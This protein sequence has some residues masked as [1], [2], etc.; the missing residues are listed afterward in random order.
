M[1]RPGTSEVVDRALDRRAVSAVPRS[2]RRCASL[3]RDWT[4][5]GTFDAGRTALRLGDLGRRRA[6]DAG[7]SPHRLFVAALQARPTP[8]ASTP[9]RPQIESDPRLTLE[10]K[11]ERASTPTSRRCCRTSSASS[12]LSIS[13]IFSIGAVIGA[14]ITMY[15]SVASRTGGDRHAARAGLLAHGDPGRVSRRGAAAGRDR[16]RRRAR[17][18]RRSCRR[19]RSR[20]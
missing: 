13:V 10:A 18:A 5:V 20:R 4:V 3:P 17:R 2:A 14:M 6:D 8:T 16:R 1:F 11:R 15:A 19:S 9:S 7:V 12:A